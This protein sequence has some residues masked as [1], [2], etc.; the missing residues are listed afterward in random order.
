MAVVETVFI[1]CELTV[2]EAGDVF[3][4]VHHTTLS[5]F[6]CFGIFYNEK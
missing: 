6:V 2:V 4:E 5:P 3:T 1:G